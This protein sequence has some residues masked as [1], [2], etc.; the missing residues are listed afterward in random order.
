MRYKRIFQMMTL[1]F[2]VLTQSY[3]SEIST[4]RLELP[5]ELQ[6]HILGQ[7]PAG[8]LA[9]FWSAC[10][11]KGEDGKYKRTETLFGKMTHTVLMRDRILKP[12]SKGPVKTVASNLL[13]E[14]PVAHLDLS[15]MKKENLTEFAFT[16]A[17]GASLKSLNLRGLN[18]TG[19][20]LKRLGLSQ[21]VNLEKLNLSRNA[22]DKDGAEEVAKL[23]NLTHLDLSK[24]AWMVGDDFTTPLSALKKL[25]SLKMR[26]A[27]IYN[28]DLEPF[29]ELKNL[30]TLDIRENSLDVDD[31]LKEK[32]K[33]I[34]DLKL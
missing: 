32:F 14:Y 31:E 9:K 19:D 13:N 7:M 3:G 23:T 18:L 1:S 29:L 11:E 6:Q 8:D 17:W 28:L 21:L 22:L 10:F 26:N 12:L 15:G 24:N 30:T 5:V 16:E 4:Q 27:G 2:G 20:E 34:K 25:T 33:W